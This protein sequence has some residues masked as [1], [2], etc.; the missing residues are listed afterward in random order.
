MRESKAP[1]SRAQRIL[2]PTLTRS[3]DA[4]DLADLV[5]EVGGESVRL[6]DYWLAVR[7]QAAASRLERG[8][9]AQPLRATPHPRT[10][11]VGLHGAC[12]AVPASAIPSHTHLATASALADRP[13]AS[14]SERGA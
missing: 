10:C 1:A 6:G 5:I 7:M 4:W 8:V 12:P 11:D 3:L 13:A 9:G 2:L 14:P